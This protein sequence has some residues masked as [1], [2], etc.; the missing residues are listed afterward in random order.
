MRRF[1]Y[2]LFLAA[3]LMTLPLAGLFAQ[4][5][6]AL[7]IGNGNYTSPDWKKLPNPMNDAA[8][9][10]AALEKLGFQVDPVI[11]GNLDQMERAVTNFRRKL[12]NS[13]NSYGFFFYAG[14]GVQH[15]GENFL[16]PIDANIP[17]RNSLPQRALSVSFVLKELEDANN[18]L[19]II[20]IDAC[21]EFLP[22]NWD[23]DRNSPTR[24]L[25]LV[26]APKGSIVSFATA[27]NSVAA[28]GEGRNGLYTSFLLKNIA[29]PGIDVNEVFR[30]TGSDVQRATGGKQYPETR[31]M[32]HEIAYLGSR[33]TPNT[34]AP[35]PKE[36][37]PATGGS[38]TVESEIAG[39]IFIDGQATGRRIK[40]GGSETIHNV[41]TGNTEVWVKDSGG[42]TIKAP[43]VMVRQGQ[44]V[45][46]VIERPAPAN[47]VRI[48]GG[49]F[50]MG[51]PASE[52]ERFGNEGPQ[53]QVTVSGFYMGRTEVTQK[54]YQEITG[55]NPSYFK[56][57][58]LPVEM[59]SWYDAV[60]YCN[61]RS[62][63]EGLTPAYTRNG[64]NVTWN[65]NANGYRLPTEAEWEYACRAGT[66][67]PFSTGNNITTSQANYDGNY[68]Y[69]NN[70]KGTYREKTTAV[71]SF[72]PNGWGLYDMH[73]NVWEWC[74]DWYGAYGSGSQ[75]DP[76]GAS[77]GSDR[78]YR[79]G[80][81]IIN[82]RF[83]RSASRSGN[84]PSNRYNYL[85]FR[86]VRP[87]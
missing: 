6:Y 82:G 24:G 30:R 59:V 67:A 73:G 48:Q 4:Q 64:D 47:M 85:G 58:N 27:A 7:V 81:W 83:V 45:T 32:Y 54:E 57:D 62:Q 75:T 77:S 22:D 50:T 80:S 71:G 74:W 37:T 1:F 53:R 68:P 39:E 16:I 35:Q 19:N 42:A 34:P 49:T 21:R 13:R 29:T 31:N 18:E 40:A 41:S 25:A 43:S 23:R 15:Q 8:D 38:V 66:T 14:H 76:V 2:G 51:S 60:E 52:P 61:K 70:A 5:K 87:E 46:A 3:F 69:N 79:G 12:Y 84:T 78:V 9:M 36:P 10:K 55:T 63:K 44:T 11:N 17:S 28:D 33:P 26:T 72:A 56:G 20:V 65:R 86:L